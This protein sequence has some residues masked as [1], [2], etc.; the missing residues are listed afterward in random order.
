ML[1]TA[2]VYKWRITNAKYIYLT[3]ED[4]DENGK[5]IGEPFIYDINKEMRKYRD[6]FKPE[7]IFTKPDEIIIKENV[8]SLDD[9]WAYKV[10]F[11]KMSGLLKTDPDGRYLHLLEYSAY[12]K[13]IP[14]CVEGAT[15]V[16]CNPI[17]LM[18]TADAKS[19]QSGD[20]ASAEIYNVEDIQLPNG[21]RQRTFNITFWIP[22]GKDGT[23]GKDGLSAYEI[24]VKNGF[25]GTTEE[26]WLDSLQGEKGPQ[27][28]KGNTGKSA[29]QS[30]CENG[31]SEN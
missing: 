2:V 18:F 8:S 24:A 7:E 29:F 16:T 31:F 9:E 27:G 30:A 10:A 1:T 14:E 23:N 13:D 26:Q 25:T 5:P 17:D 15:D 3:D 22:A 21:S 28:D 20:T 12:M 11:E 19:L 4:R 6:G